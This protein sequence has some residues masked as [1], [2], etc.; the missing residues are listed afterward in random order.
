MFDH[1]KISNP[2]IEGEW[3]KLKKTI[4]PD[5]AYKAAEVIGCYAAEDMLEFAALNKSDV[6]RVYV[7]FRDG[8]PMA[9]GIKKALPHVDIRYIISREKQQGLA[10]PVQISFWD[11]WDGYSNDIAWFA[12]PMNA[13]GNTAFKSMRFLYEHFRFDTILFSHIAANKVGIGKIQ[14]EITDFKMDSYMNYAFLSTKLDPKTN[15]MR[16][17]LELTRDFGD[18]LYGT[19]GEDYPLRQIHDDI[20]KLL[21][22]GVGDVEVI[23]KGAL[24]YLLQ[25]IKGSECRGD[26]R[27]PWATEKW[28]TCALMWYKVIRSLPFKLDREE[29]IILLLNDLV[30]RGFL[31]TEDRPW[32]KGLATIYSLTEKGLQFTSSIYLPILNEQR[33]AGRLQKDFEFLASLRWKQIYNRLLYEA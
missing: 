2:T 25:L 19:L 9:A 14:T 12:D 31:K 24:L 11:P 17:G 1:R 16:D 29:Q 33:I 21:G 4:S 32:N 30:D 22:T 27:V 10:D 7:K 5:I 18:K 6:D 3:S 20:K 23:L 13:T 8:P 15:Y 26:R 28:I